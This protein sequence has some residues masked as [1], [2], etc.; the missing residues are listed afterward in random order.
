MS[1]PLLLAC[2]WVV[3]AS[4]TALLPLRAQ[5]RPGLLLLAAAVPLVWSLAL[6]HG[7][8]AVVLGLLVLGSL[9]RRPLAAAWQRVR[10]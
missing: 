6:A 3:A 2:L 1:T 4:A 9:F 5:V 10:P 8:V 7:A